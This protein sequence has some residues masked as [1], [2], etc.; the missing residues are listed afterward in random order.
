MRF[1]AAAN[2]RLLR[3]AYT[4]VLHTETRSSNVV[5]VARGSSTQC[6]VLLIESSGMG[7]REVH[8]V[9][10]HHERWHPVLDR[11][12]R[13]GCNRSY[14][15]S[16]L[17][18]R[19]LDVRR[20]SRSSVPRPRPRSGPGSRLRSCQ[21]LNDHE[22]T[23][24]PRYVANESKSRSLCRSSYPLSMQRVAMIVS[25]VLRMVTPRPRSTR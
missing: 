24:S 20:K 18:Q 1:R 2:R 22:T 11:L 4:R 17:L 6:H 3:R 25:I 19:L 9:L 15:T 5:R 8:E 10:V 14:D 23:F 7:R 16:D 12:L 21:L 13:I